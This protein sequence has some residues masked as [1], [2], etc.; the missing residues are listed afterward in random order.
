MEVAL[1]C[2]E[3]GLYVRY[4]GDALALAPHFIAETNDIDFA[5]NVL[6]DVIGTLK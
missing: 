1:E 5:C 2:W 6:N 4:A 3:K